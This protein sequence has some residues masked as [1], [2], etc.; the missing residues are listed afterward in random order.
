M[1]KKDIAIII[2]VISI[3]LAIAVCI[4]GAV[5]WFEDSDNDVSSGSASSVTTSFVP[6]ETPTST[7]SIV[8]DITTTSVSVVTTT[9]S[10]QTSK[11]SVTSNISQTLKEKLGSD[12]VDY[13]M[14][15]DNTMDGWGQGVNFD[16]YNRPRGAT[17]A[18][19]KYG[20][21]DAYFIM[22][23]E[24]KVYLTF[25]EGYENG[26][27]DDI[28]DT[29]KEK[30][31]SAVFFVTLS[32]AKNKDNQKLIR[33]MIDEGHI[34]GNHSSAHL[35]FPGMTLEAAY[36]DITELHNYIKNN[37]NYEMTLFRYPMGQ[38][39]E[40]TMGLLQKLGYKTLFWSYAYADWDPDNQ[41]E[42]SK[43]LKK[44]TERLHPGALY[45]LHA[46]SRTNAN[47]LGDVIDDFR[48]KG[49]EVAKFPE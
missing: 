8:S 15:L 9:T 37:F 38:Y 10:A 43:A 41:M 22:P 34:V 33:R 5:I 25:D 44:V 21:Y 40:R 35:S 39:S 26:Y 42:E 20:K 27:T 31:V 28:L 14:S 16:E 23:K 3:L 32:Y 45:L 18:Q 46:V 30:N 12:T 13:L 19:N 2:S 47:I 11:N 24:N 49:Y 4:V 6:S 1:K 29:L 7:S 17:G 48:A 36:D